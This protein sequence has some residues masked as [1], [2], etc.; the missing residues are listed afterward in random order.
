MKQFLYDIYCKKKK[1]EYDNICGED[2]RKVRKVFKIFQNNFEMREQYLKK[3]NNPWIPGR[4]DP[5]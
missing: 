1:I 3:A 2:V 4:V 5:V